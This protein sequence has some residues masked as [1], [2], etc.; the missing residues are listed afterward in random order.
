MVLVIGRPGMPHEQLEQREF[1]ALQL[2]L[3]P[4]PKHLPREQIH[5][6]V[7]DRERGGLRHMRGAPDQRLE[8]G[9]QL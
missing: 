4:V 8:P 3:L 7:A 9:Q 6:Q 5:G 1:A 2:D